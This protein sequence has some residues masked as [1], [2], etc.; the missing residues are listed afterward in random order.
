MVFY[1]ILSGKDKGKI[2]DLL[3][4]VGNLL[5]LSV[6]F[7][8]LSPPLLALKSIRLQVGTLEPHSSS[9]NKHKIKLLPTHIKKRVLP[10]GKLS[11]VTYN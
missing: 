6:D 10:R 11:L 8:A 2:F 5:A 1:R 9:E 4:L 7:L 3:A